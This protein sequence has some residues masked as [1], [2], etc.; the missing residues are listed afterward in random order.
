[1]QLPASQ[2]T[3]ASHVRAPEHS[4]AQV[5]PLHVIGRVQE[6]GLVQWMSH[7]AAVHE[8]P[9][10]QVPAAL[11]P[12]LQRLPP[13]AIPCVHEPAPVHVMSHLLDALQSIVDVHEPAPVQVTAQG[14][15]AGQTMGPVHVLAAMHVT[16]HVPTG[17]QVPTP[18]SA[19]MDG[20]AA[21]A[22]TVDRSGPASMATKE[23]ATLT[24]ML[25]SMGRE[26]SVP[27]SATEPG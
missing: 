4:T 14:I 25:V 7:D 10:V 20:H 27:L 12:R 26:T 6:S 18:A 19:Q 5:F 9:P 11:Q 3:P 21:T 24:S 16:V 22:S 15:P 17:S 23:S 13:H 8:I 2:Q 1:V